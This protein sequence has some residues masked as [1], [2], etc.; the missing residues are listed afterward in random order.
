MLTAPSTL[1]QSPGKQQPDLFLGLED[2]SRQS[3]A[4]SLGSSASKSL[5]YVLDGVSTIVFF[6]PVGNNQVHQTFLGSHGPGAQ[7]RF[8]FMAQKFSIQ[9]SRNTPESENHIGSVVL[10]EASERPVFLT[11]SHMDFPVLSRQ[12][13]IWTEKG[14]VGQHVKATMWPCQIWNILF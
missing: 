6:K 2:E 3:L 10:G 9:Q 5:E 13:K 8:D 12:I 4:V 14:M 11:L 1:S 7:G